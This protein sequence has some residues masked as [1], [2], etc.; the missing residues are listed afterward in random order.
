MQ[1]D[2]DFIKQYRKD[3]YARM[4]GLA[5]AKSESP[6][7]KG[8]RTSLAHL[9]DTVNKLSQKVIDECPHVIENQEYTEWK[10][11][12]TLGKLGRTMVSSNSM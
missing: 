5:K 11:E 6:Y 1:F 12:D 9:M 4:Q 7:F 8:L 3:V 2:L 10:N